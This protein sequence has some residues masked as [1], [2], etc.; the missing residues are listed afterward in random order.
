MD[1]VFDAGRTGDAV[2]PNTDNN[3]KR[4]LI[5]LDFNEN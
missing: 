4:K 5:T 2:I 1:L 3:N